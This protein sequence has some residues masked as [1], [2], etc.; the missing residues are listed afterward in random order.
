MTGGE[1]P[2]RPSLDA[3]SRKAA[4]GRERCFAPDFD[5]DSAPHAAVSHKVEKD[6]RQA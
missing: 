5:E 4:R 1:L 3:P 2:A 6:V